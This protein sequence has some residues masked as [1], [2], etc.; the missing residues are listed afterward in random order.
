MKTEGLNHY[1]IEH[2]KL[3]RGSAILTKHRLKD[4]DDLFMCRFGK[5]TTFYCRKHFNEATEV[6]FADPKKPT[7]RRVKSDTEKLEEQL[8]SFFFTGTEQ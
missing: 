6:W 3:G 7:R 2:Y 5:I 4:K 1:T 8:K